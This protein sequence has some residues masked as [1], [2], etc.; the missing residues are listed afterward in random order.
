MSTPQPTRQ[1][2]LQRVWYVLLSHIALDFYMTLAPPLW[3]FFKAHFGLSLLQFSF[4]PSVISVVGS[5]AQPFMGYFSDRRNRMALV[6]LG[7]LVC[8]IFVSLIGFAPS[9]PVLALF[10]IGATLGSSLF[11]PTAGGLVTALAPHR[12]NLAM[13]IFLTGGTLGMAIGAVTGTRIVERYGLE[14]LWIVV[15]PSLVLS[16]LMFGLSRT[17]LPGER[18]PSAGK[19]DFGLLRT[20]EMRPLWV[21]YAISVLRSL[22]HNG[23]VSFTAL[24]GSNWEWSHGK[25]GWVFSAYLLS[26][27]LGRITGGYLADRVSPRKLLAFSN[28]SSALFYAA[29]CLTGGAGAVPLFM[30]AGFLFDLG[31]TTNITLAQRIMPNN[32][33][34]ATGLVMGFSWGAAGLMIPLMGTLAEFTTIATALTTVSFFLVPATILVGFLPSERRLQARIAANGG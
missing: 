10:L 1:P 23:F 26:S 24:L 22:I 27:T 21:L 8:G 7:L 14:Q 18:R 15:F 16:A 13:A 20:A 12:S 11:H 6:A 19:V 33:S 29:F 32:T 34:T 5:I 30:I 4:L 3:A 28:A 2:S 31:I 9:A 17:S 25:I